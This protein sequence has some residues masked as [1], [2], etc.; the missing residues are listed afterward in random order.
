MTQVKDKVHVNSTVIEAIKY[1]GTTLFVYFKQGQV[2]AY[3]GVP[4]SIFEAFKTAHSK[5]RYFRENIVGRYLYTRA[6]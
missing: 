1:A 3:S 2:Y 5:G 4:A 6:V